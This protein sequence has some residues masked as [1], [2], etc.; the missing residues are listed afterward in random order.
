VGL[1]PACFSPHADSQV[2]VDPTAA[3][4]TPQ[5]Q[6]SRQASGAERDT[7]DRNLNHPSHGTGL[8]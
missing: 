1:D 3:Q 4:Q 8:P 6:R 7:V 2:S 5:G